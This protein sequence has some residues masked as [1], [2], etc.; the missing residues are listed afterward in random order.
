VRNAAS[1]YDC[2]MSLGGS[3]PLLD[4]TPELSAIDA[5]LSSAVLGKGS[6]LLVEGEMPG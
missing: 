4:R 3:P 2:G 5:A 1:A 6:T